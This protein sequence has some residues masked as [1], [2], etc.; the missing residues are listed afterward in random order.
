MSSARQIISGYE[1]FAMIRKGQVKR[2]P[3][4]DM[5]AQRTLIASLFAIAA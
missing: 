2:I 4:N 5:E 3:A 1:I